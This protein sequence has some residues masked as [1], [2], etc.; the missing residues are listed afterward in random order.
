MIGIH[1]QE[2]FQPKVGDQWVYNQYSTSSDGEETLEGNI[3]Y[4]VESYSSGLFAVNV[5]TIYPEMGLVSTWIYYIYPNWSIKEGRSTSTMEI[6][7]INTTVTYKPPLPMTFHPSSVN[8]KLHIEVNQ[9]VYMNAS[10]GQYSYSLIAILDYRVNGTAAVV[11][12]GAV[13]PVYEVIMENHIR[14]PN[15]GETQYLGTVISYINN[16]F[17]LPLVQIMISNITGETSRT[18]IAISSYNLD[19]DP[20]YKYITT[21]TTTTQTT[22]VETRTT[23]TTTQQTPTRTTMTTATT[24]TTR[25]QPMTTTQQAAFSLTLVLRKEGNY[26]AGDLSIPI[27]IQDLSSGKTA[28]SLNLTGVRLLRLQGSSYGVS[29][30]KPE[31]RTDDGKGLY[32]F[33][34]WQVARGGVTSTYR[35]PVLIIDLNQDTTVTIRVEVYTYAQAGQPGQQEQGQGTGAP[36]PATQTTA[37]TTANTTT[38]RATTTPRNATIAPPAQGSG[39]I[40]GGGDTGGGIYQ[41]PPPS[42]LYLNPLV[43]GGAVGGGAAAVVA[44]LLLRRRSMAKT[45]PRGGAPQ[46]TYIQGSVQPQQPPQYATPLPAPQPPPQTPQHVQQAMQGMIC[47]TCG[48]QNPPNARFCRKCGSQLAQPSGQPTTPTTIAGTGTSARVCPYCGSQL[49]P[50]AKFCPRCGAR[51]SS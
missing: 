32:R 38:T 7:E 44:I 10:W 4:R 34:E 11:F 28:A 49:S 12:K 35:D 39:S 51:I 33:L 50:N 6:G 46:Q 20:I 19:P 16:D 23:T 29:I 30:L 45:L 27:E 41:P 21:T 1:A 15:T 3:I 31:G 24:T 18:R 40:G 13:I 17:K 14:D 26:S 47:P 37:R 42:P 9:T 43:L 5:T 8:D 36:T 2:T 25:P 22:T 48:A